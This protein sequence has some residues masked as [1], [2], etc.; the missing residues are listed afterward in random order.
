MDRMASSFS[1]GDTARASRVVRIFGERR[2]APVGGV[3]GRRRVWLNEAMKRP[4]IL[5]SLLLAASACAEHPPAWPTAVGDVRFQVGDDPRWVAAGWDDSAWPRAHWS[6]IGSHDRVVWMRARVDGAALPEGERV[7]VTVSAAGAYDIFWNGTRVG[8]SGRPGTSRALEVPG[9]MTASAFVAPAL[10]S[11]RENVV[12]VRLSSFHL[13][14]RLRSTMH[15]LAVGQR[16]D[17]HALLLRGYLPGTAAG[18]ALL[19]GACYF[20][21]LFWSD[22]R[23][24]A[25]G[26]LALLAVAALGQLAAEG[27][28]G[29][30]NYAYPLHVY[31]L[32]AILAAACVYALALVAYVSERCRPR[33]RR[34][35]LAATTVAVLAAIAWVPGYD[36]K[37]AVT[38]ALAAVTSLGIAATAR[39]LRPLLLF[40][41]V[42][43]LAWLLVA[44]FRF[45]DEHFY[46]VTAAAI[47]LLFLE[48]VR[49]LRSEQAA[50][51]A[52]ELRSARLELELLKRYLQPHFLLNTLTSLAE[53][54]ETDPGVGV[55]MIEALADEFRL[56]ARVGPLRSVDLRD[57]LAL[58]RLHLRVMSLRH[59]A[60]LAL[61]AEGVD[62]ARQ[63][64]PAVLHTLIEN[65]LTHN[66]Y[67][68]GATF[69]VQETLA[70]DRRR[71]EL[72][73]PPGRQHEQAPGVATGTGLDYVR[74]RL[75][76][77]FADRW[78]LTDGCA[79]DGGWVTCIE[80]PA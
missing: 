47:V 76:E 57:E 6:T 71:Y 61:D 68:Q 20:A 42:G 23:D 48:Q 9:P 22:R 27:W 73:C 38:I 78:R 58:C 19:L 18:G 63:L 40:A 32:W 80:V 28:R 77:S 53:W 4:A 25:A 45:L 67:P 17:L 65:A 70:G 49:H 50:R 7:E 41:P 75:S 44:P 13:P 21:A 59:D 35:A 11:R 54:V 1:R 56:L 52:M 66:H 37:T 29:F 39:P 51:A 43:L 30:V 10:V 34:S 60:P 46:V 74:A 72:R 69:H 33:W 26:F 64:P 14:G 15:L 2:A 12:A 55:R 36:G 62:E 8:G 3:A 5:A 31:R 16:V 24:R 79:A